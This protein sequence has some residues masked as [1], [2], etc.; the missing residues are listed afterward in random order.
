MGRGQISQCPVATVRHLNGTLNE[1]G[2]Q[3]LDGFK[4]ERD[5]IQLTFPEDHSGCCWENRLLGA[6][7]GAWC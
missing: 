5:T 2:S 3:P 4:Q 7:V 6:G 1:V